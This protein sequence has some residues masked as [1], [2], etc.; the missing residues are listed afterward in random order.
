MN[1][2][3]S[4]SFFLAFVLMAFVF[5]T[6]LVFIFPLLINFN[7]QLSTAAGPL[8]AEQAETASHIEDATIKEQFEDMIVSEKMVLPYNSDILGFFFQYAWIVLIVGVVLALFI[9]T[10]QSVEAEIG[11]GRGFA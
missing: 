8:L 1:N 10:R 4:I 6:M 3:G 2:K 5:L 11:Y 9:Y 7:V